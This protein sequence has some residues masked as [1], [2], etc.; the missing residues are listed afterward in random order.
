MERRNVLGR[1]ESR[2]NRVSMDSI[3]EIQVVEQELFRT[4][5][6]GDRGGGVNPITK[7]GT[8][9]FHGSVFEYYRNEGL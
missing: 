6:T 9:Q 3:Q 2:V 5:R 1:I 4:V 8:N 7:S